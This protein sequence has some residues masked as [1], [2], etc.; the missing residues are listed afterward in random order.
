MKIMVFDLST[1]CIGVVA[2]ELDEKTGKIIKM[3]SCPIIPK[4]FDPTVLGY[5]KTKKKLPTPKGNKTV[6]TYWKQGETSV[7]EAEKKRRDTEVRAKKDIYILEQIGS[8]M[9]NLI[10]A[11]KPDKILVEKNAIFNG[12]LTTVLLAK[13]MGTL[14]GIGGMLGI[15]IEEYPVN[16]VRSVL[17]IPTLLKVFTVKHTAE[18]LQRVPDV[19]KRALREEMERLY[20][21]FGI[22]FQTDDESDACVVWHYWYTKEL[23]YK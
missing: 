2:A 17:D 19:T 8:T 9:G 1:A 10:N 5:M 13:V 11:I 12:I 14:L 6:N 18:E 20:G 4:D 7:T 16:V 3:K 22:K 23:W 15:P 21:K